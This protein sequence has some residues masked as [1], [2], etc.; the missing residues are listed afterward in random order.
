MGLIAFTKT[1]AAEGA[2]YNI[3]ANVIVPVAAS[4]MTETIMSSVELAGLRPEKIVPIVAVLCHT[5]SK[6]TGGIFE[7]AGGVFSKLRWQRAK[8][9]ALKTDPE[10][11]T[12]GPIL[13]KWDQ[14]ND[15]SDAVYPNE[16]PDFGKIL[17]TA[18]G[19]PASNSKRSVDLKGR[20][21]IVTGAG[22][23]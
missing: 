17:E 9:A 1:L 12:P 20:V 5:S 13:D 15:F 4:R 18:R 21:A 2:K 14:V 8:G 23:G 16:P 19:L 7:S 3:H 6:E 22:A 11:L 10:S